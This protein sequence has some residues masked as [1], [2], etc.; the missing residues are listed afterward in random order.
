VISE[1]SIRAK[2]KEANERRVDSLSHTTN[3]ATEHCNEVKEKVIKKKESD[4][5]SATQLQMEMDNKIKAAT[6][7]KDQFKINNTESL[8]KKAMKVEEVKKNDLEKI[9]DLEHHV[10]SK[11]DAAA[12]RKVRILSELS[13]NVSSSAKKKSER[14]KEHLKQRVFDEMEV[15]C[16]YENRMTAVEQR[17]KRN[18]KEQEEK[19]EMIKKRREIV[20]ENHI[21]KEKCSVQK[22]KE[23]TLVKIDEAA[24]RRTCLQEKKNERNEMMNVRREIVLEN[25]TIKENCCIQKAKQQVSDKINEADK[26][27]KAHLLRKTEHAGAIGNISKSKSEKSDTLSPYRPFHMKLQMLLST[28]LSY[29]WGFIKNFSK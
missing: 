17:K 27:R 10:A 13:M 25:H 26:R 28:I 1:E 7:R 23:Q 16:K 29:I 8:A 15:Q 2:L 24:L 18:E 4:Q 3:R 22:V 14:A 21:M 20:R 6:N 11:L 12:D 19:N 9:R 5:V